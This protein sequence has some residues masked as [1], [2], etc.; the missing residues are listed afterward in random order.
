MSAQKI[1][2]MSVPM[3]A[4]ASAQARAQPGAMPVAFAP[5]PPRR[6]RGQGAPAG[7]RGGR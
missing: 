7:P 3:G 4:Q 5:T 2:P 6:A 1:V